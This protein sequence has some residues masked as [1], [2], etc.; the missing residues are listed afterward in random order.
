VITGLL[1]AAVSGLDS[2]AEQGR[3]F[4]GFLD[5][6]REVLVVRPLRI[7]LIILIAI[8]V[9]TLVHRAITRAVRSTADSEVPV[10]LRPLKERLGTEAL[11]SAGLISER[12]RQRAETVGSL[13]R[14][15]AS[16]VVGVLALMLVFSEVGFQLGPFIAGAGIV[17]IALGFG[18]QNLV[19]DF[20]SGIFM[21]LEDQY[22]VG[23][24]VDLGEASGSVEGV[25]L[26][27]TRLR[28]ANGTVWYV[29]NGEVLRVGNKTQGFAQVI[30]DL[31]VPY[32]AD[33]TEVGELMKDA[34]DRMVAEDEWGGSALEEPELLGVE[35]IADDRVTLRL[36][37]KVR[38]ADQW[39]VAR[40][41]RRRIAER[42][43]AGERPGGRADGD[44]E[45]RTAPARSA[46]GTDAVG[47]EPAPEVVPP[48]PDAVPPPPGH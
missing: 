31:P 18:A 39:K 19:K 28:D 16:L 38:P 25:G 32:D 1:L 37:L 29:R 35:T 4:A 46:S 40:E 15:V 42:L 47:P 26:R 22:G 33:L 9:R 23:D 36:T 5:R 6:H 8:M 45:V 17:G 24:V 10:V 20:L 11:E 41:L 14:S 43:E 7:V 13:L 34:A 21:L 2:V 12:R 3:G 27:V 44:L 30:I 48:P